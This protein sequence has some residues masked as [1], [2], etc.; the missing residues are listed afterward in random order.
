MVVVSK[1][2][3][4]AE[5]DDAEVGRGNFLHPRLKKEGEKMEEKNG[6]K[7]KSGLH[8]EEAA[9]SKCLVRF[10]KSNRHVERNCANLSSRL[11]SFLKRP[12]RDASTLRNETKLHQIHLY[13]FFLFHSFQFPFWFL[14]QADPTWAAE[15]IDSVRLTRA[16]RWC[17]G[18]T[19]STRS[20]GQLASCNYLRRRLISLTTRVRRAFRQVL[21]D[22]PPVRLTLDSIENTDPSK[23]SL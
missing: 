15:F 7:G 11:L 18:V 14:K 2:W 22:F 4:Q 3:E 13:T 20:K 8:G 23:L 19:R 5:R 6:K 9:D 10:S 21:I 16:K 1:E 17:V 12:V